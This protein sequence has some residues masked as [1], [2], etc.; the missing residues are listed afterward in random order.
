M[1]LK[2]AEAVPVNTIQIPNFWAYSFLEIWNLLRKKA[3]NFIADPYSIKFLNYW[4]SLTFQIDLI[5]KLLKV[6]CDY[7]YC[8]V[9]TSSSEFHS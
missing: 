1:A 6:V 7:K 5:Q 8:I 9:M 4:N 2:E 3:L